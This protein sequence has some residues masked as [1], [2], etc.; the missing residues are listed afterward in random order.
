MS[1]IYVPMV[2]STPAIPTSFT[3]DD[4]TVATPVANNLNV[5]SNNTTA[6]N[7]NGIETIASGDTLTIELTNRIS[8][9][10]TTSDGGG[11]TQTVSLFTPTNATSVT[12]K[13][14]VSGYDTANDKAIGGEQIG[15]AR[16]SAGVVTVVGTND[17]FDEADALL[18]AADWNVISGGA[19]LQMQFVG[20]AGESIAWRA[21][22]EYIQVS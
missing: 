19:N 13:A 3:A 20:V 4:L 9:T 6:N 1:Q 12:F 18:A 17:T 16:K 7:A 21:T 8:V 14:L 2:S 5:F 11:Q 10:A 22:F 15:L